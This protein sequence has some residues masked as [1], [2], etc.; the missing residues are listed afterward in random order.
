[1]ATPRSIVSLLLLVQALLAGASAP[2]TWEPVDDDLDIMAL[3]DDAP[4]GVSMLQRDSRLSQGAKQ[5]ASA[6]CEGEAEA[7]LSDPLADLIMDEEPEAVSL[8]QVHATYKLK[9]PV[10]YGRNL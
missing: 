5:R 9:Q 4:E 2:G 10:K 7:V 8:L 1:M 6:A 3:I